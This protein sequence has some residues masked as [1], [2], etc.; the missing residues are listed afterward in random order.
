V[1]ELPSNCA[2]LQ[3]QIQSISGSNGNGGASFWSEA[4]LLQ[5]LLEQRAFR[6][7]VML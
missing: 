3:H 7:S 6:S 2:L 1:K 4:S 5:T